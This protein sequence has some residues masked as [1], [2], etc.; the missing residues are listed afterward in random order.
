MRHN[1]VDV[2]VI[3]VGGGPSG[4]TV[5]AEAAAHGARVRVLDKRTTDPVLCAGALLP[6][7]L[8]LF[9]ARGIA[10][11]FIRRTCE[12]NPHP[13]Q[14]WRI[15]GGLH[16]ADGTTPESRFQ[17]ALF[18]PQHETEL[19]LRGWAVEK[20]VDLRF[21]R[22]VIGLAHDGD[23]V[24]VTSRDSAGRSY[25]TTARYVIGADGG[26]STIRTLTGIEFTG[27]DATFNGIIADAEMDFPWPGSVRVGRNDHGWLTTFPVGPGLTR[28]TLI[29][30]DDRTEPE[31]ISVAVE[32]VAEYVSQ[33]LG[34]DVVI[35][36]L[37]SASRFTDA[38][39]IARRF[40][41]GRVF[42]VGESVR[43]HYPGSGIG[44]N[45][46]LQDAFNLGWKL[47]AVLS[48]SADEK[49]LNTYQAERRPISVEL[50]RTVDA[51]LAVQFNSNPAE[52]APND[53]LPNQFLP[54]P[55]AAA[56]LHLELNGLQ[57]AYPSEP[58]SHPQTG[59]PVPDFELIL[60]NGSTI[61]LYELLRDQQFI[62]LDLSGTGALR[63]LELPS[64]VAQIVEAHPAQRP[65]GLAH[66]TCAL[67]RPDTYL[68]WATEL[69][70]DADDVLR[71]LQQWLSRIP[72][73]EKIPH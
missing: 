16:S 7:P 6:R 48:G 28:F 25:R 23:Q 15:W 59:R 52:L 49:L 34:E 29:H 11:R 67:I 12:I 19:V 27:R 65:D 21:D 10:D 45:Y 41:A 36:G 1:E 39:R 50:F 43:I 2:D 35:P 57:N 70:P 17:F 63:Y 13:F 3:V 18:L 38:Q 66:T 72:I 22:N 37:R 51:Q 14:T 46:C 58:G 44:M 69:L 20:G 42:L 5:A 62:V 4:L 40:R 60:R 31:T 30:A 68:A 55:E 71:Q 26:H 54:L 33:I 9:D 32:E 47:A 61:R 73:P 24:V 56:D 53:A 64:S 8:E